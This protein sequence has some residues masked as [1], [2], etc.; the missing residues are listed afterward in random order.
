MPQ[1]PQIPLQDDDQNS[2]VLGYVY[3]NASNELVLREA[4][5]GN[6]ARLQ[7]DGTFKMPSAEA[8]E[9]DIANRIGLGGVDMNVRTFTIPDDDVVEF[10]L[11]RDTIFLVNGEGSSAAAGMFSS[12][13]DNLT[14][15]A[16]ET[17]LSNEG[18]SDLTGTTGPDES[19]NI[20]RDGN[21]GHIE[22]RLG[23]EEEIHVTEFNAT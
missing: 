11:T 16:A 18:N 3:V 20:S 22:N 15:A 17:N 12:S 4:T 9:A 23:S 1:D 21:V 5:N 14:T 6:E 7:K 19:L 8:D 10:D 2:T 13:F